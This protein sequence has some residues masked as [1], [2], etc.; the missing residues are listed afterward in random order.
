MLKQIS[1]FAEN[2][3]GAMHHLTSLLSD[4]E[5]N[6]I[7]LVTNDS[8]EFGIIRMIVSD[9]Q[10]A[11]EALVSDGYMV[12]L[13]RVIGVE[14]DDRPGGLDKILEAVEK[15]YVNIDYLYISYDRERSVPIAI[16][17]AEDAELEE[18]LQADGYQVL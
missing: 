1:V 5:I 14:M 13:D 15:S 12:H 8:A 4:K 3:K 18:V 16:M 7:A 11:Y 2:K 17:H 10:A 9:P 6:I